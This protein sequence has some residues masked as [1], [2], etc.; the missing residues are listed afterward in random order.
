MMNTISFT[1]Q[2]TS[3]VTQEQL[4]RIAEPLS[5]ELQTMQASIEQGYATAYAFASVPYDTQQLI[6]VH[7]IVQEKM[8]LNPTMLIV[9]GIG[10]SNL[11][12]IAV[13]EALKGSLYNASNPAIKLHFADTVDANYMYD[14]V[15]LMEQ[16]LKAGGNVLLNVI[17]K[18]GTTTETIVNFEILLTVLERYKKRSA[19]YCIVTT[20]RDSK[21]WQ[22]GIK[23]GYTCL[24]IPANVGGRYSVFTSV[25]LFPLA[26]MGIDCTK[27]L[28]G[29]RASMEDAFNQQFMHNNAAVRAALLY[30]LY[31]RHIT[32]HDLFV[33]SKNLA[34]YNYW[35]RQLMAESLGK[36]FNKQG[37]KVNVG[38]TPTVSIGTTDLHSVAQLYLAGAIERFTTFVVVD[39]PMH[40]LN[41]PPMQDLAI[42]IPSVEHLELA[43]LM[44]TINKGVQVA[45]K[46]KKRPFCVLEL[47]QLDEFT[48]GYLMQM[49]MVEIVLLGSLL[50]VN[51]FD[52]PNVELYKE[53][54]RTMLMKREQ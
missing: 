12:A 26:L 1:Y 11:G 18:S 31:K 16:E 19:D 38:I 52:Q 25:G 29:A 42:L 22:Y 6:A 40:D 30:N 35:Y 24:E 51:P 20:D 48:V 41:I 13:H 53:E 17:S 34:G 14:L 32:I 15:V 7:T 2:E 39:K 3:T 37:K 54:V 44:N 45:Y 36:E 49:H 8:Q 47:S 4:T 9:I 23:K 10:G 50:Q 46:K 33:F 43:T 5:Q 21:L 27:L 28:E